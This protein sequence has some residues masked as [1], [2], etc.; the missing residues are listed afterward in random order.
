MVDGEKPRVDS[1]DVSVCGGVCLS[2]CLSVYWAHPRAEG[3]AKRLNRPK[4]PLEA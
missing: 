2:A 1:R 3:P 4:C